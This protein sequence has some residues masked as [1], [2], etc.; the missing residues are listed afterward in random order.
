[1]CHSLENGNKEVHQK[2]VCNQKVTGH[3]GRN[4]PCSCLAGRQLDY[5]AIFSGFILTTRSWEQ[6]CKKMQN[7]N[8]S[9][10]FSAFTEIF[11]YL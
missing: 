4:N 1:M 3:D 7:R 11:K 9:Y 10:F 5:F 6:K 2:D 8:E